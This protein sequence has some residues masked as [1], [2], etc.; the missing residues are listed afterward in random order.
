MIE[1]VRQSA[2]H[3]HDPASTT[4][5][6]C[7]FSLIYPL[8]LLPCSFASP[9][10]A[11]T[12][13]C[14][15]PRWRTSCL[16]RGSLGCRG[17]Q[18][19]AGQADG[20]EGPAHQRAQHIWRFAAFRSSTLPTQTSTCRPSFSQP[21][22]TGRRLP[23]APSG[24][25]QPALFEAAFAGSSPHRLLQQMAPHHHQRCHRCNSAAA[26]GWLAVRPQWRQL[27]PRRCFERRCCG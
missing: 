9:W 27:A 11:C 8:H 24:A 21:W 5:L 22:A 4:K 3:R 23:A 12:A 2:A 14:P 17:W 15:P 26:E 1:A 10:P 6:R 18:Q 20:S 19:V 16:V 13:C 7:T 25:P